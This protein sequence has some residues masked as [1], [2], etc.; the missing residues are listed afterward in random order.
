MRWAAPP[1]S[2]SLQD[3]AKSLQ[4]EGTKAA[5]L[6]F[7][8]C[9]SPASQENQT[10]LLSLLPLAKCFNSLKGKRTLPLVGV[11]YGMCALQLGGRIDRGVR[12]SLRWPAS[13][14]V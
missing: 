11:S 9:P 4:R 3:Q 6:R 10:S 7:L 14:C 2:L 1:A 13:V 12:T 8:N 5:L